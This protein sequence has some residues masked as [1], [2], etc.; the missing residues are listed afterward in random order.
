MTTFSGTDISRK[1]KRERVRKLQRQEAVVMMM[2]KDKRNGSACLLLPA[3]TSREPDS[4]CVC[5]MAAGTT[6]GKTDRTGG[7]KGESNRD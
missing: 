1:Q 7:C 4:V 3:M 5:D 2:V 6:A